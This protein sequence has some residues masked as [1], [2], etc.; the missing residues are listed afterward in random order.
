MITSP[1]P[2]C[3]KTVARNK[4]RVFTF[5]PRSFNSS[6]SSPQTQ[7]QS[8]PQY[9]FYWVLAEIISTPYCSTDTVSSC[10][11]AGSSEEWLDEAFR[12]PDH[13]MNEHTLLGPC[14]LSARGATAYFSMAQASDN[15]L[16]W[17]YLSDSIE[18][19]N[20]EVR[21]WMR[22]SEFTIYPGLLRPAD[23]RWPA[24]T[25]SGGSL[26]FT[27][28]LLRFT[29]SNGDGKSL[30]RATRTLAEETRGEAK[31]D[32]EA[33]VSYP[34]HGY[35]LNLGVPSQEEGAVLLLT[36][37]CKETRHAI[38]KGSYIT[39]RFRIR[40]NSALKGA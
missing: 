2:D 40:R 39:L 13:C 28:A 17:G 3:L 18:T 8:A 20:S 30:A 1:I 6:A 15:A 33:Y 19:S 12:S 26:A 16:V 7:S 27:Q 9:S 35:A 34:T 31:E 29:F 14:T 22:S 38:Q 21:V 24:G 11:R 23:L 25:S 32:E 37:N 10:A 36:Y 4:L 5:H